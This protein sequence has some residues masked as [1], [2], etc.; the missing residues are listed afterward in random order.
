MNLPQHLPIHIDTAYRL[1]EYQ[2]QWKES[3]QYNTQLIRQTPTRDVNLPTI[4]TNEIVKD[5]HGFEFYYEGMNLVYN[6]Y[7][8]NLYY[9]VY[10]GQT[11]YDS[12]Q[13]VVY[14]DYALRNLVSYEDLPYCRTEYVL[15]CEEFTYIDPGTRE[16]TINTR[17]HFGY[18]GYD[19]YGNKLFDDSDP[20][21]PEW[22]KW[23]SNP[24][25]YIATSNNGEF[26]PE[27]ILGDVYGKITEAKFILFRP[28]IWNGVVIST[29]V[30]E[31]RIDNYLA[32]AF[33]REGSKCGDWEIACISYPDEGS[34][35]YIRTAAR[36]TR[37]RLGGMTIAV[38]PQAT[39]IGSII[40]RN[41]QQTIVRSPID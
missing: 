17:W 7:E 32:I 22:N 33:K 34:S 6:R 9:P 36:F 27:T 40:S 41:V 39:S 31:L 16:P 30:P 29:G 28:Y 2:D 13:I 25:Y 11:M 4:F 21:I 38:K 19:R 8:D 15:A 18:K 26:T 1:K 35:Q 10:S 20:T 24:L 23:T 12:G 3:Y 5:S 14:G 37:V